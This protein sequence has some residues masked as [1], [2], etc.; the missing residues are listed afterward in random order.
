M[1]R[2]TVVWVWVAAA[3]LG[4]SGGCTPEFSVQS[5]PKVAPAD[6]PGDDPDDLGEPPDWQNCPQGWRGIY[7]NL[8]IDDPEVLPKPNDEPVGTDPTKLDWWD[9]TVFEKF[10]PTLDFGSNWWPVDEALEEDPAYFAVYWH[11]WIRAWSG[12]TVDFL[13]GSSDDAWIYID[14]EPVAENPG[15]HELERATYATDLSAGVYPIEVYFAHRASV[16]AGLSLRI[17]GGD[18]SVCYPDFFD[19]TT[20]P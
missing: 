5:G 4:S 10:D 14:G 19:G 17:V 7:S 2:D 1:R 9:R 3:A 15:I 20:T 8:V 11:A 6:P 16:S 13:L 18:V 12:T